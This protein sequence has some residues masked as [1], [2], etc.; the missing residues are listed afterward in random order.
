MGA[1]ERSEL[2][3]QEQTGRSFHTFF[4]PYQKFHR[5]LAIYHPMV[6][7]ERQIHHRTHLDFISNRHRSI[8]DFMHSEDTALRRIQDRSAEQRTV[9]PAICNGKDSTG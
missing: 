2:P 1:R 9:D 4:Y 5:F 8:L 6:V 3:L 7:A